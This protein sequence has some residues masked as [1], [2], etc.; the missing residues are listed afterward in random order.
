MIADYHSLTTGLNYDHGVIK[1][2]NRIREDTLEMAKV[3]IASGVDS[4]QICFF[5]Q[6][7][8][9][10]HLELAWIFNC[11]S[12]QHWLNKMIQ[13]KEKGHQNSSVGLYTYPILMA[14]DILLYRATH[15][16]VGLDQVQHLELTASIAERFN[17]LFAT[18]YFPR[19]NYLEAKLPKVMSLSD[20]NKKMSK[21]DSIERSRINLSDG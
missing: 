5:V 17:Q 3:L 18:N 2:N 11:I 9:P 8:V 16:P 19:P 6:S 7:Q 20:P 10:S 1:Y 15:I 13:F 12:P 21:S 4:K 14:S